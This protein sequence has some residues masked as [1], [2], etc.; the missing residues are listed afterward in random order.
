[1]NRGLEKHYFQEILFDNSALQHRLPGRN[2][3]PKAL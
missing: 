2:L 3:R 1:M